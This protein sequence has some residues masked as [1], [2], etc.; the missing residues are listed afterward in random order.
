MRAPVSETTDGCGQSRPLAKVRQARFLEHTKRNSILFWLLK[1]RGR[2]GWAE[3][4]EGGHRGEPGRLAVPRCC[5]A[6]AGHAPVHST[7]FVLPGEV[8]LDDRSSFEWSSHGE[9]NKA[10][11]LISRVGTVK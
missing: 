3:G 6:P 5:G 2:T 7:A 1:W 9:P 4:I 8:N 11:G 10:G